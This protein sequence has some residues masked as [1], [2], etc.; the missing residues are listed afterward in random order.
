MV[1]ASSPHQEGYSTVHIHH[2]FGS[3]VTK[4]GVPDVIVK[5]ND[6]YRVIVEVSIISVYAVCMQLCMLH[7]TILLYCRQKVGA[8][9]KG[10]H[11]WKILCLGCGFKGR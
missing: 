6:K 4:N 2:G 7:T 5:E 10:K 8:K 11:N 9:G 1:T 3:L